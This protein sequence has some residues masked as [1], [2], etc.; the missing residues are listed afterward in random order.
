MKGIAIRTLA[1]LVI[2]VVAIGGIS[3]LFYTQWRRTGGTIDYQYC[4][5]WAT[6]GCGVCGT[7]LCNVTYETERIAD[8]CYKLLGTT[9]VTRAFKTDG[10]S[11]SLGNIG[12]TPNCRI[13]EIRCDKLVPS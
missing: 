12:G 13:L 8:R 3:Y 5:N 2:A 6:Q 11:C 4:V 1:L 10:A 7:N 9:I